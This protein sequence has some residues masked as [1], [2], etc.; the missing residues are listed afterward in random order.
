MG[1][2]VT[3]RLIELTSFYYTA[4]YHSVTRAARK[5]KV[6]QSVVSQHVRRLEA[7]FGITL[8]DRSSRP[9]KLTVEGN[10]FLKLVIPIVEA[11]GSLKSQIAHPEQHGS[12]VVGAYPDLVM[13][14]LPKI[15][16]PFREQY[17]DVRITL[18]AR[19]YDSLLRLV[20][21]GEVDLALCSPP[22]ADETNLEYQEMFKYNAVLL[23]PKG[24]PLADRGNIQLSD[25]SQSSLILPGPES[26]IW[27]QVNRALQAQGIECE[28]TLSMDSFQSI[29]RYVEIDMGVAVVSDFTLQPEDLEM[30][31]VINLDHLFSE[32]A[33][34]ICT[35]NGKYL[36]PAVQNF[37]EQLA[38]DLSGFRSAL[39]NQ[40]VLQGAK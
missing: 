38:T 27:Q 21:S 26:V 34:G 5:Q 18:L 39:W 35:L 15:I 20:K 37:I 8:F 16:Q 6:G 2:S 33:I 13:H 36:G 28:V 31:S 24:H 9:Y 19:P 29:K 23:T 14:H 3:L 17:P 12:F 25:I 30:L 11:A 22:P 1:K 32:S 4:R 7:E 40:P 10:A